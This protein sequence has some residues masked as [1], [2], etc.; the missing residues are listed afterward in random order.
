LNN[1]VTSETATNQYSAAHY[2][3]P[4][5]PQ[6]MGGVLKRHI[7]W[8]QKKLTYE[9]G[10]DILKFQIKKSLSAPFHPAAETCYLL[11]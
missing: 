3:L 6:Q 9:V 7:V 1:F 5:Y 4:N 11:P 8:T 2:E 10:Y